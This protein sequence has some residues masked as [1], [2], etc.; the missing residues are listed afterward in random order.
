[1]AALQH[2]IWTHWMEYL[3]SVSVQNT[4]GT[5]TIPEALVNRWKRQASTPYESLPLGE[6]ESDKEQAEKVI[7]LLDQLTTIETGTRSEP[8]RD[9]SD[10]PD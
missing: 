4:D 2:A 7:A 3:F 9:A 5:V 6:T 1:M 10:L 8:A